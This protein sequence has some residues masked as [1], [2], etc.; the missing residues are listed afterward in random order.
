MSILL[1]LI[2]LAAGAVALYCVAA[3][4]YSDNF[5]CRFTTRGLQAYDI[6]DF[7]SMTRGRHMFKSNKGQTLV[8]YLYKSA[9]ARGVVV[10]AH[11]FGG[12]GQRGYM[13]VFEHLTR[14]G[15]CVFAYDATANDESEGQAVGGLPQGYIDLDHAISYVQTIDEISE[16]PVVLMGYS[17]GGLSVTNVLNY[18]PEVQAVAALSGWNR[19]MNLI[20][21]RGRQIVGDRIKL[22]LPFIAAH[23]FFKY[24]EYA[25]SSSMKG[26]ENTDCGVMIVHGQWDETIPI[27]YGYN[28]YYEQYGNDERFEFIKYDNRAHDIFRT[29][30]G[31]LDTELMDRIV[32]FFDRYTG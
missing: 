24:G 12:G 19:S 2:L 21:Y 9:E 17:W 26:F 25:F 16:L 10:F 7:P 15:Y 31:K 32:A 4:I 6:A 18:H 11:G 8:G 27:E 22:L 13:D 14:N 1:I 30:S 23:E 20:E 5:N 3:S 28:L 29:S